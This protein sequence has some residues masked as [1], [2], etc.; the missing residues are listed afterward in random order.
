MGNEA[1]EEE[2]WE[3]EDYTMEEEN[4]PNCEDPDFIVRSFLIIE[5]QMQQRTTIF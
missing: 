3:E 5:A 4:Q 2:D 1:N